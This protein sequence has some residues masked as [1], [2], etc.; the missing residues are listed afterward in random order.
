M[1]IS[2]IYIV[3]PIRGV[4]MPVKIGCDKVS[5]L[6]EADSTVAFFPF[7]YTAP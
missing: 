4:I 6:S 5:K 1:F 3:I 7:P 2:E